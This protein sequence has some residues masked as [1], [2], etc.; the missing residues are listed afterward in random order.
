MLKFERICPP[1]R[2]KKEIHQTLFEKNAK[3]YKITMRKNSLMFHHF[4]RFQA[5]LIFHLAGDFEW[6]FIL[7]GLL[8][9]IAIV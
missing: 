1:H 6:V 5:V 9:A 3:K 4:I 7:L 2:Y 8:K